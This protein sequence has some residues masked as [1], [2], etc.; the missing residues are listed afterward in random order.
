[1]VII[2]YEIVFYG[3]YNIQT[4]TN[5]WLKEWPPTKWGKPSCFDILHQIRGNF[6]FHCTKKKAGKCESMKKE[7]ETKVSLELSCFFRGIFE[8]SFEILKH[9]GIYISGI[10]YPRFLYYQSVML[11]EV[12]IASLIDGGTITLKDRKKEDDEDED[13][14]GDEDLDEEDLEDETL[15]EVLA[16]FV[17]NPSA[18][19]SIPI[20]L[21]GKVDFSVIHKNPTVKKIVFSKPGTATEIANLPNTLEEL[22]CPQQR[23]THLGTLPFTLKYLTVNENKL[24]SLDL[25]STPHLIKLNI[26]ENDLETLENIPATLKELYCDYN[27]LKTIEFTGNQLETLHL[28]NNQELIVIKGLTSHSIK[29][30]KIDDTQ[31]NFPV[32]M[33]GGKGE[34]FGEETETETGEETEDGKETETEFDEETETGEETETKIPSFKKALDKYYELKRAYEISKRKCVKCKRP[35]GSVFETKDK[36]LIGRCGHATEPCFYIE[37]DRG[38]YCNLATYREQL[39]EEYKKIQQEI[40]IIKAQMVYEY[41]KDTQSLLSK[42]NKL[43]AI[44]NK[45]TAVEAKW[46][47]EKNRNSKSELVAQTEQ[48]SQQYLKGLTQM[49]KSYMEEKTS[50]NLHNIVKTQVE[51]YTPCMI[52]LHNLQYKRL[53]EKAAELDYKQPGKSIRLYDEN[54]FLQEF[55]LPNSKQKVVAWDF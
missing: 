35:S 16:K 4:S 21:D 39:H 10:K 27:Y 2:L 29:D 36:R 5:Q 13:L 34:E 20:N 51:H 33:G 1:M 38:N 12:N 8:G 46:Q 28:S 11:Q 3:S 55:A 18:T 19:L 24:K 44:Q 6:R 26:S 25:K 41:L 47:D 30:F 17:E 14:D 15:Q 37:I 53:F 49:Y 9:E 40:I 50:E 52:T 23:L 7:S 48:K 22:V 42:K 45:L 32:R 43:T 31:T 54:Y